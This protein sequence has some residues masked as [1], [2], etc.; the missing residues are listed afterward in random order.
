MDA[1]STSAPRRREGRT[2]RTNDEPDVEEDGGFGVG[3]AFFSA[4]LADPSRFLPE[5]A[6][7]TC[8]W[9]WRQRARATRS[10]GEE[11]DGAGCGGWEWECARVRAWRRRGPRECLYRREARPICRAPGAGSAR[12]LPRMRTLLS[13]S[14]VTSTLPF[15]LLQRTEAGDTGRVRRSQERGDGVQIRPRHMQEIRRHTH[16]G[17]TRHKTAHWTPASSGRRC[18]VEGLEPAGSGN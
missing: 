5:S 4:P 13:P 14:R 7:D 1:R 11:V 16:E 9:R 6:I 8:Y 18:V 17:T 15:L 10:R 12:H 2:R 3:D